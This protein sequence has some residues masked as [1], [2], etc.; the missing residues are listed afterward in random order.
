MIS[1]M[2][3]PGSLSPNLVAW[4]D[5]SFLA[6]LEA[7]GAAVW[8]HRPLAATGWNIEPA[9]AAELS[10]SLETLSRS[11][12]LAALDEL[13][14][15]PEAGTEVAAS[16]RTRI[17]SGGVA[18]STLLGRM[19]ELATDTVRTASGDGQQDGAESAP[20]EMAEA[21]VNRFPFGVAEI[22]FLQHCGSALADILRGRAEPGRLL[23]REPDPDVP[24]LYHE[25]RLIRATNR[26]LAAAVAAA[27][28]SLPSGRTLRLLELGTGGNS[29]AAEILDAMPPGRVDL[30]LADTTESGLAY[31]Q[32]RSGPS[33][34][35]GVILDFGRDPV[36][37]GLT[38]QGYDIL[39]VAELPE[40]AADID[41][42]LEHCQ[43]LLAPSGCLILLTDPDEPG[44]HDLT[45]GLLNGGK[46][47]IALSSWCEALA[48]AG[49]EGVTQL[50]ASPEA[51]GLS[52]RSAIIVLGP[53]APAIPPGAWVI[54]AAEERL[55]GELADALALCNQ[56]VIVASPDA[57]PT[58]TESPEVIRLCVALERR[59]A[60]RALF[61]DLPTATPLA[62]VVYLGYAPDGGKESRDVPTASLDVTSVSLWHLCRD[63]RMPAH[64]HL[65]GLPPAVD[66]WWRANRPSGL[67]ARP[68]GD[69]RAQLPW[70][71]R[72]L[73]FASLIWIRKSRLSPTAWCRNCSAP[74]VSRRLPGDVASAGVYG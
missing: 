53:A 31:R 17:E 24:T 26:L 66:R 56:T 47:V 44:W 1:S 65:C 73:A 22:R 10:A 68:C 7:I 4:L 16:L 55:A 74:T 41:K 27:A 18:G 52:G 32:N 64:L 71:H 62:G 49:F 30:T 9:A 8:W 67:R 29:A 15:R 21:L 20:H 13:G 72:S 50:P 45:I 5:A 40:A 46:P 43:R 14:W 38:A 37:Q 60:W 35:G 19:L 70:R 59:E 69:L 54:G 25:S 39:V 12:A 33:G 2:R 11:F 61:E 23:P 58:T 36:K 42:F 57:M 63:S 34:S 51:P 28:T 3:S 48:R 6:A